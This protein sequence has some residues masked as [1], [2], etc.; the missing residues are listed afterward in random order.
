MK[1]I[2]LLILV[3]LFLPLNAFC[4]I[5]QNTYRR[6]SLYSLMVSH[7]GEKYAKEI[8]E[9]FL[10][11][12]IPDKFDDND[13]SVKVVISDNKKAKEV[14]INDFL[15]NNKVAS[16]LVGHWYNRDPKTGECDMRLI[17]NRGLKNATYTDV[18]LAKASIRGTRILEDAGE[19]LISNTFVLVNDIHYYDKNKGAQIG[20]AAIRVLGT[21]A[22]AFFGG[23]L[24]QLADNIADL[25]SEIKGFTVTI[26]SYLYRLEWNSN[27]AGEFYSSQ[28]VARGDR[29]DAKRDA[30]AQSQNYS[31][32]YVGSTTIKS[33][34][35][36]MRGMSEYDLSSMIRKVC[37]RAVDKSILKL[38]R[39]YEEFR[40]KTPVA[41]VKG[42]LVT[43]HIGM[44]E[45]V[46]SKYL[47]E[48][49]E[50]REDASGKLS[51]HRV[52]MLKPIEGAIADNRFMADIEDTAESRM[53]VTKFKKVSGSE[54]SKGMLIRE[55]KV[56]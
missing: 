26:N 29:N 15:K 36:T 34:E 11:I 6:S 18:Q 24:G 21:V 40:V 22:G 49:L 17:A 47:Y 37:A 45:G 19:E 42:D 48:V 31:L 7:N 1:K 12:P 43:A 20:A 51:Y 50:P 52:A 28:Y 9:E 5:E 3:A 16:R 8:E 38:Q 39:S 10:R 44:R 54:I 41:E 53:K 46:S 25:V 4:Q 55:V 23:N 35:V 27:I 56:Q 13:L 14:Q 30:F 2:D 32:K 33:D